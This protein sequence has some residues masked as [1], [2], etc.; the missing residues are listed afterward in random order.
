[1]APSADEAGAQ[2]TESGHLPGSG[3]G[4]GRLPASG[5]GWRSSVGK[6]SGRC[7]PTW[8]QN[9][10]GDPGVQETGD[11]GGPAPALAHREAGSFQNPVEV[12]GGCRA[13][14]RQFPS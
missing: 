11:P 3:D 4:S 1:M 9:Q 5:A 13:N 12:E 6:G 14:R 10:R 8:V 2:S 7:V